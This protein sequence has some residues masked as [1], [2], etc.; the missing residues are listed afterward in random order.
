MIRHDGPLGSSRGSDDGFSISVDV[1]G[2]IDSERRKL[3]EKSLEKS[4]K[5]LGFRT[6]WIPIF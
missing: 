5:K 3:I 6:Q 1:P 4:F 2:P